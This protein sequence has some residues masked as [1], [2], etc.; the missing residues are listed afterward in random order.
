LYIALPPLY[1][2]QAGK[3]NHYVYNDEEKDKMMATLRQKNPGLK[4][5]SLQRYKGL[6]EMNPQQ[7]WETTMDPENRILKQVHVEDAQKADE[8]FTMLMGDEVLPRK[9][10]IQ[11]YA[12]NANLDV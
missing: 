3:E 10:F 8:I 2:I 11:M 7:L 9:R 6:G 1:K 5:V 4:Q 12:K